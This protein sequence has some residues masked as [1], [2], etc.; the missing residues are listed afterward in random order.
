MKK[1]LNIKVVLWL[2]T[3]MVFLN[4]STSY[5]LFPYLVF[6]QYDRYINMLMLLVLDISYLLVRF[7]KFRGKEKRWSYSEPLIIHTRED[8]KHRI[9]KIKS[10]TVLICLYAAI[11]LI[12]IVA[13]LV[14]GTGW[15]SAVVYLALNVTFFV[16]LEQ[17]YKSYLCKYGVRK[18]VFLL[19][20]GYLILALVSV[21]SCVF[22]FMLI[23]VGFNPQVNPVSTKYDLFYDNAVNFD[24]IYYFPLHL[25]VLDGAPD[26]RL[27]F[28]QEAGLLTGFYH[29]PHCLTFM[30]FPALFLFLYYA[31]K[32]WQKGTLIALYIWIILLSASTTNIAAVLVTMVVYLFFLLKSSWSKS[33]VFV[34]FLGVLFGG[35]LSF[36]DL[37]TFDFIFNKVA[38][39]SMD[40]SMSTIGFALHPKSL[41][42]TNFYNLAFVNSSSAASTMD[43][44]Y[45]TF[46]LN[47]AFLSCVIWRMAILFKSNNNLKLA[48]LLF[49]VYFFTHSAKVAMVAY[50]LTMLI[51]VFFLVAELSHTPDKVIK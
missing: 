6:R 32:K 41:L 49:A 31:S 23:R 7:K 45:I 42:G 20:R 13:G 47:I 25:C 24:A 14:T 26:I 51:F 50:S 40:Y 35:I 33:A 36:V 38:S 39:G 29:E 34:T 16:L 12:C 19:S 9:L 21:V 43:V 28:F 15:K 37:S 22:M 11:S 30:V 46:L 18:S 44:G 4:L 8:L 10:S 3:I 5:S 17:L 1:V 2:D 27:P 48:V